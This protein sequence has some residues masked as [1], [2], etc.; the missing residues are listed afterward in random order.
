[1]KIKKVN[2]VGI[3]VKELDPVLTFYRDVLGLS[4]AGIAEAPEQAVRIAY[5]PCGDSEI[6][7]LQP[8]DPTAGVAIFLEKRG[9]SMHHIC[10]EVE[11]IDGA[12]AELSE[13]G[14]RLIDERPRTSPQGNRMAFLHPKSTHGVLV[15]LYELAK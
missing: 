12:L 10:L 2:H 14:I 13:Q 8:T 6:E 3:V 5:L 7:L 11:D 1:M 15:E 9:E 4:V